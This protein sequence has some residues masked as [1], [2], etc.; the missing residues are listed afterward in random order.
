MSTQRKGDEP[1]EVIDALQYWLDTNEDLVKGLK[2]GTLDY[3]ASPE[4]MKA[5][6]VQWDTVRYWV[7]GDEVGDVK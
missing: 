6:V 4:E 2:D 3:G 1:G 5:L 7:Y